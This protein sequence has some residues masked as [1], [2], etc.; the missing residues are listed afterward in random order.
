MSISVS[1]IMTKAVAVVQPQLSLADLERT[2]VE[3]GVSGFPVTDH[4]YQ[5]LGVVARSDIVRQLVVERSVA[6]MATD[7]YR[8]VHAYSEDASA[9]TQEIATTLGRRLEHLK[10]QD[11]MSRNLITITPDAS[12]QALSELMLRK[13][14]HRVP[15]CR[16]NTLIGIVSALDLTRLIA[17]GRLVEAGV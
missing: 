10:V 14:I 7:F 2:F 9:L 11:V 4:D 13:H 16:D 3:T 5:L 6:E 1:T 12:L 15:V 8:D 17:E